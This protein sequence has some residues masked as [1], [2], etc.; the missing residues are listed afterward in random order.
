LFA[1]LLPAVASFAALAAVLP[2][3]GLS[4]QQS[5]WVAAL[6]AAL[7][8]ALLVAAAAPVEQ[9][10][11]RAVRALCVALLL[12][13]A[14]PLG[15]ARVVP[16]APLRLMRVEI[17][18]RLSQ[19]WV[20]DPTAQLHQAPAR[21]FCATAIWSPVG[22]SDR[23]FHVWRKDGQTRARIELSISG[24]RTAGYRTYSRIQ[25]AEGL[26]DGTYRCSVETQAG[27]VLGGAAVKVARKR[28][29]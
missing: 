16:A 12:P 14:L 19:Q 17:G 18:T 7:G 13:A 4:T 23:L 21:L 10:L 22:V 26:P 25:Q 1:P 6:T 29:P 15:L 9:R 2:G 20:A 3:L 8:V 27:Q 28:G 5:L 24:G 11:R